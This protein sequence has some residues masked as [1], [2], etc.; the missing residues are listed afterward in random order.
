MIADSR[1]LPTTGKRLCIDRPYLEARETILKRD[2]PSD[3]SFSAALG[4]V[5]A[6]NSHG[7]PGALPNLP[8][9][10]PTSTL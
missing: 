4:Y 10:D 5:Q 2:E 8:R 7:Y 1:T 9:P 3:S 6:R